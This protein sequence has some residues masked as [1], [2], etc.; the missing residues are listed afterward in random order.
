MQR[1][2]SSNP[3]SR[4]PRQSGGRM[5]RALPLLLAVAAFFI[6]GAIWISSTRVANYAFRM[7]SAL[8]TSPAGTSLAYAYLG[9]RGMVKMLTTPL[10]NGAVPA[11]A[12][13]FRIDYADPDD[14]DDDE[15]ERGNK[16]TKA[17]PFFL[18]PADEEF[19]RGGGRLVL[20][21]SYFEGSMAMRD[22]A[23]KVAVKV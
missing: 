6:A 9:R 23:G 8:N 2:R 16:K 12:I 20:A 5:R 15:D 3:P 21:S 1:R 17:V 13:V 18:A 11:N 14:F 10:R 19:V 7:G 4:A 22:D